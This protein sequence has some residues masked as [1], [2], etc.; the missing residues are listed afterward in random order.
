MTST[1]MLKLAEELEKLD[2]LRKS[3][4][5]ACIATAIV[6][7][8]LAFIFF[9]FADSS[10]IFASYQ[11]FFA[12]V[13]AGITCEM[14][15]VIRRVRRRYKKLYNAV[16]VRHSLDQHFEI[17]EFNSDYGIPIHAINSTNMIR[18][19]NSFKADDFIRGKYKGIGFMQSDV[20]MEDRATIFDNIK[21][22]PI[23]YF[24]GRWMIF[25][26]NKR[27]KCDLLIYEKSFLF[28][29][30]KFSVFDRSGYE[31]VEFENLSFNENFD[32]YTDNQTEA[33]YVLTPQLI[34]AIESVRQST[35]GG[36]LLCFKN[37]MLHVGVNCGKWAFEPPIFRKID[38]EKLMEEIRSDIFLITKFVDELNLDE[39]P[40]KI[41]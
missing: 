1:D 38:I 27:F 5:N 11:L 28:S 22:K 17:D 16:I 18:T 4:R 26:F 23:T 35:N 36:L 8:L 13:F 10:I 20:L 7:I 12:I 6:I 34:E 32:C 31:K 40:Y 3:T 15:D 9:Y 21:S 19:G 37:N 39:K 25:E 33:F 41:D 14:F 24:K 30:T 29:K 2:K